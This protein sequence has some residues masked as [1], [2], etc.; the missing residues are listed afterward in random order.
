MPEGN[1]ESKML[2]DVAAGVESRNSS[3]S[4]KNSQSQIPRQRKLDKQVPLVMGLSVV[5]AIIF[6]LIHHFFYRYWNK[7]VVGSNSEQQWIIRGGTVFAFGFKTA[8]VT[9]SGAAYVQYLWMTMRDRPFRVK[10][11]DSMFSV[12]TDALKFR[13]LTFWF[14]VPLLAIVAI[15]TW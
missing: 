10:E 1:Y 3:S 2:P 5:F 14:R 6:A 9:G 11:I 4:Q 7:R 8:L 15:I 12:L 13:H